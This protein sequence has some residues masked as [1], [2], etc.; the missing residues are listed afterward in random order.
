MRTL[1]LSV[2]SLDLLV[3]IFL[4]FALEDPCT[5]RLVEASGLQNVCC[6]DVVILAAAHHM[7][8][9]VDPELELPDRDLKWAIAVSASV[10][11]VRVWTGARMSARRNAVH[12]QAGVR[13]LRNLE[14]TLL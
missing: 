5:S 8:F 6:V 10:P 14:L 3:G 7:F 1:I 4:Y 13:L 11:G 2:T 12:S 9:I